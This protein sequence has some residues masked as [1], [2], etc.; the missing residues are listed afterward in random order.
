VVGAYPQGEHWDICRSAPD[1]AMLA[2]MKQVRFP[3]SDPVSGAD[4]PL[5]RAWRRSQ[6]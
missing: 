1:A 4:G 3:A 6:T 2:R 5:V